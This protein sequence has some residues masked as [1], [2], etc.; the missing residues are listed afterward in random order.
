MICKSKM[1]DLDDAMPGMTLAAAVLD[2]K[3]DVLLPEGTPLSESTLK[4]LRRRGIDRIVMVD[5]AVSPAELAAERE[6]LGQRLDR[7]FRQCGSDGACG[8]LLRAV[9]AYRLGA[10]S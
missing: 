10:R 6:R 3:G 8:L 1:L 7:L 5:D 2:N 4:S 9:T